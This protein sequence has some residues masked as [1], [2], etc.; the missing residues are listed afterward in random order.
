MSAVTKEWLEETIK[1]IE[2]TIDKLPSGLSEYDSKILGALRI[3]LSSLSAEPVGAFHIRYGAVWSTIVYR[4]PGDWSLQEGIVR[5]FSEPPLTLSGTAR[6]AH[7]SYQT[8]LENLE[9]ALRPE[10][11]LFQAACHA[12]WDCEP[13]HLLATAGY[14][15]N[16]DAQPAAIKASLRRQVLTVTRAMAREINNNHHNA[17]PIK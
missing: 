2:H 3:A 10:S 11:R 6:A 4:A 12:L 5:V 7:S 8:L 9:D 15:V 16:F 13:H 14:P 17:L 1:G